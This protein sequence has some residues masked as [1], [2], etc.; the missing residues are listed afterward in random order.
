MKT[1]LNWFMPALV[2]RSVGSSWG[3][4][5]ELSAAKCPR[6]TKKFRKRSRISK[7]VSIVL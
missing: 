5:G 2:N 3:M 7:E 4:T 1:F 6:E